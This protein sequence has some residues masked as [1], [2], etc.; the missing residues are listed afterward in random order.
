MTVVFTSEVCFENCTV[1]DRW[2]RRMIVFL[3][4]YRI[5]VESFEF[6]NF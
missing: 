2:S 4:C 6:L 3:T 1:W 5:D